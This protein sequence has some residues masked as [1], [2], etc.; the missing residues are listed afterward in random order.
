MNASVQLEGV[1]LERSGDRL[2][3][4]IEL[5]IDPGRRLGLIGPSGSGKTTLLRTIL[6][7]ETPSRGNVFL[8]GRLVSSA[9]KI[10]VP[11]E[12][13]NIAMVF[14]DLGLWPHM[15]ASE[16]LRFALTSRRVPKVQQASCVR[17][18]L[19][20]VGLAGYEERRPST[21]SGGERQRLAL[22][23]ALV[24]EPTLVLLDE[25]FSNLDEVLK[26]ELLELLST[27][28]SKQ[29]ATALIVTHELREALALTNDLAVLERGRVAQRGTLDELRSKPATD[30]IAKLSAC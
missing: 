22:A 16:H 1:C 8:S 10:L 30:F 17:Q 21:L 9:N 11:P 15:T 20:S 25:C 12:Q 6:G 28:L 13:R 7:L 26:R 2:L 24:T 14:Q 23:R 19:Q 29:N 18:C 5:R 27:A 4:E 3:Y